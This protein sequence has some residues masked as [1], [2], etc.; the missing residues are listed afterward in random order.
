MERHKMHA[1]DLTAAKNYWIE[2]WPWRT[3]GIWAQITQTPLITS[4][5]FN[6]LHFEMILKIS[7]Q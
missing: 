3:A 7:H 2:A 5:V 4:A 1:H 6:Y